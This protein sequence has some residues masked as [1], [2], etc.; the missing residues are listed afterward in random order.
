MNGSGEGDR[1]ERGG[2]LGSF[3]AYKNTFDE[4][5]TWVDVPDH[6]INLH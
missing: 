4:H 5:N 1:G 3:Y 6:G 2:K